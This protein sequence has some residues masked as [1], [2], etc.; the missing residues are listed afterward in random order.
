M[1]LY[2]LQKF[3]KISIPCDGVTKKTVA[4][5]EFFHAVEADNPF[6]VLHP[7][8]RRSCARRLRQ[9]RLRSGGYRCLGEISSFRRG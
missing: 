7:A 6:Y 9:W 3:H 8:R 2:K 5:P 4:P 1:L